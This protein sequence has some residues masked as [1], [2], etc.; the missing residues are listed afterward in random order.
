MPWTG[1]HHLPVVVGAQVLEDRGYF[2]RLSKALASIVTAHVKIVTAHVKTVRVLYAA[3]QMDLIR[4][5]VCNGDG[6][7]DYVRTW[8]WKS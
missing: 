2:T 7:V 1:G 5:L 6:T 3:K 8:S 4:L